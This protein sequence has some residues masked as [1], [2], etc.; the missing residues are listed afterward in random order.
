VIRSQ[1]PGGEELEDRRLAL[2][3]A[4]QVGR[5][6]AAAEAR[7]AVDEA[8]PEEIGR[9]A[10]TAGLNPNRTRVAELAVAAG[11][12]LGLRDD[13]LDTLR[14]AALLHDIGMVG[15]PAGLPLRPAPLSREELA[16]LH[17]HPIIA[18]RLLRPI[19][20]LSDAAQVLRHA[21]ERHDG[22]GYPDG[23]AGSEIP[24]ASRIL[25]AAIAY[26]AMRSPRPWRAP[27]SDTE[28]RAELRR[29]AGGQLDPEVVD[30][31]LR[32]LDARSP[33]GR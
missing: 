33:A 10:E 18:E 7:A 3:M 22:S 15:I 12:E 23:L 27:L 14:R 1:R 20:R 8:G 11:R 16:V 2:A 32:T 30:A 13:E 29:A 9:L 19:P 5:A 17:E 4:N 6:L 21:H 28:A 31:L 24:R 25:H 26:A